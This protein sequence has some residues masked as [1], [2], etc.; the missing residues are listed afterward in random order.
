MV[1]LDDMLGGELSGKV[2][3]FVDPAV[4]RAAIFYHDVVYW[5]DRD[6]CELASAQLYYQHATRD[7]LWDQKFL[8]YPFGD[9]VKEAVLCTRHLGRTVSD[10]SPTSQLVADV[11]VLILGKGGRSDVLAYEDKIRGEFDD[12]ARDGRLA[13]LSLPERDAQY[14]SLRHAALAKLLEAAEHGDLYLTPEISSAYSKR[15]A[16]NLE[17]LLGVVEGRRPRTVSP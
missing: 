1:Y 13:R 11:D 7:S 6:D 17:Y 9:A 16:H 4:A 15:A 10:P 2:L 5:I 14:S 12:F 8:D 3:E